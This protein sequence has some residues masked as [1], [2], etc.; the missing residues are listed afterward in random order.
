MA[1]STRSKRFAAVFQVICYCIL[2]VVLM[3]VAY[4]G[5]YPT[6]LFFCLLV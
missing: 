5:G 2:V 3:V 6:S 1:A 4:M